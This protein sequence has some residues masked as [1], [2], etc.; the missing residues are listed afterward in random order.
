MATTHAHLSE[1][2]GLGGGCVCVCVGGMGAGCLAGVKFTWQPTKMRGH[3][4]KIVRSGWD[5]GWGGGYLDQTADTFTCK[6]L[7]LL[8]LCLCMSVC[9]CAF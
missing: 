1:I 5:G 7:W 9:L 2:H 8:L 4:E 6:F 3:W